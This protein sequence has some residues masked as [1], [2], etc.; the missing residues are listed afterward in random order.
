MEPAS[1][2]GT[3]SLEVDKRLS[4][5]NCEQGEARSS[6]DLFFFHQQFNHRF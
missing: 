6:L 1:R 5:P 2:F 4:S 3:T